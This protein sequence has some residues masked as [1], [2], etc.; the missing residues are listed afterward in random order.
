MGAAHPCATAM[1]D[2][3]Q[4]LHRLGLRL[5]LRAGCR[6]QVGDHP[7]RSLQG[8]PVRSFHKIPLVT[9]RW[10]RRPGLPVAALVRSPTP[11]LAAG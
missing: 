5:H 9:V 10:S 1:A 11:P 4:H 2:R 8:A 6:T 7:G 3:Q